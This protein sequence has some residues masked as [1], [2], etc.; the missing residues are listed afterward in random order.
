MGVLI[1]RGIWTQTRAQVE[2]CVKMKAE[3]RAMLLHVKDIPATA[4]HLEARR[5]AGDRTSLAVLRRKQSWQH[6]RLGLPTMKQDIPVCKP[7]SV[8]PSV[9]PS[10]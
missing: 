10:Q 9:M 5:E 6:L 1:K 8:Q 2:Q 4:D 7:P 3:I